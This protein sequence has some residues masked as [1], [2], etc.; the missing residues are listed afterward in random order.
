[1]FDGKVGT[2]VYSPND[3]FISTSKLYSASSAVAVVVYQQSMSGLVGKLTGKQHTD[4]QTD[5]RTDGRTDRRT[6]ERTDRLIDRQIA[7]Q[8]IRAT[9]TTVANT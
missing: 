2:Y 1:M 4:R 5:G 7:G 9:D 8:L 3:A 6:D